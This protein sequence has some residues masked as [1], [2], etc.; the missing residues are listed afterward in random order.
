M[1]NIIQE[2]LLLYK[3]IIV[4]S[5]IV[6]L[7][8]FCLNY[9]FTGSK[10]YNAQAVEYFSEKLAQYGEGTEVPIRSLL[11]HRSQA[12]P[13]VRHISG[14][15]FHEFRE[16]LL[17]HPENFVIDD[18]NETVIL[19]DFENVKTH[20]RELHFNLNVDIDPEVTQTLLDFFAQCI[21]VKGDFNI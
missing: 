13:E 20:T 4:I 19:K 7:L 14:Q 9:F 5:R 8:N 18:E 11:G 1:T 17:K 2:I 6:Y 21:E 12:S 15:H 10:D 16:F 3:F